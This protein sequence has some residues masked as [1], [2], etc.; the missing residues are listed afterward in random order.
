MSIYGEVLGGI[1]RI[2]L[3]GDHVDA[4]RTEIAAMK[5][6]INQHSERLARIEGIL[7]MAMRGTKRIE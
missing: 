3:L 6:L 5:P 2:L 4:L 1:R 7:E